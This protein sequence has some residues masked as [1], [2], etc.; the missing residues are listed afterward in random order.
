[1][2][3]RG[4]GLPQSRQLLICILFLFS[5]IAA[6]FPASGQPGINEMQQASQD[7]AADFFSAFDL[8]LVIAAILGI[9][10]AVRIYHNWQMGADRIDQQVAAWFFA[11][12]FMILAGAFL[13]ALFGL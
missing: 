10:G 12:I 11:A 7:L 6:G 5:L 8:S 1:M 13:K 9:I 2:P 3:R 4:R